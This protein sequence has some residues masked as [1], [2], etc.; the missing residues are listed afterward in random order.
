[1]RGRELMRLLFW[2]YLVTIVSGIVYFG[3]LGV[4]HQ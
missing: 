2:I 4:L 1:V 3:V